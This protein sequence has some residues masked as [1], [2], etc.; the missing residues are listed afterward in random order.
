MITEKVQETYPREP[1]CNIIKRL[2]VWIDGRRNNIQ[3]MYECIQWNPIDCFLRDRQP[4]LYQ[5]PTAL[6]T[7]KDF[8]FFYFWTEHATFTMLVPSKTILFRIFLFSLV[9]GK[10]VW[11]GQNPSWIIFQVALKVTRRHE[12]FG[13]NFAYT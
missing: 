11:G 10:T 7:F 6:R 3:K 13:W 8:F 4:K 1:P 5:I 2:C 12:T 9:C